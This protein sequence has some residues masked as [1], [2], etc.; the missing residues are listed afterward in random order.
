VV[1][2]VPLSLPFAYSG[3]GGRRCG[4]R[5][6]VGLTDAW[7]ECVFMVCCESEFEGLGGWCGRNWVG[8]RVRMGREGAVTLMFLALRIH[9]PRYITTTILQLIGKFPP[10]ALLRLNTES[11]SFTRTPPLILHA[12]NTSTQNQRQSSSLDTIFLS[13]RY[14]TAMHQLQ[15]SHVKHHFTAPTLTTIRPTVDPFRF[16]TCTWK[17]ATAAG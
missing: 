17:A 6:H 16:Q 14:P 13:V 10:L 4:W 11:R 9:S 7:I 15:Q 5:W 2:F 1:Y 3:G 8:V 12:Q